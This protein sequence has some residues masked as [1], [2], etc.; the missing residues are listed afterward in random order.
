M[1][2]RNL[3]TKL[4]SVLAIFALLGNFSCKKDPVKPPVDNNNQNS[5]YYRIYNLEAGQYLTTSQP[6]Q[7]NMLFQVLDKNYKGAPGLWAK[8]N[9]EIFENGSPLTSEAKP[10]IDTFGAI[11]FEIKT[12]LLLDVSSSVEGMV[13]QLK[14]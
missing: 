4:F 1:I 2:K 11:P 10:V 5:K 7:V 8:E 14:Q 3:T 6:H 12:V 9:Y 13:G